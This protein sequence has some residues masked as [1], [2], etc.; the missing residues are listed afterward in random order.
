MVSQFYPWS[1]RKLWPAQSQ[2]PRKS[3]GWQQNSGLSWNTVAFH[4]FTFTCILQNL[5]SSQQLS[6]STS[7]E[8][9]KIIC[10]DFISY[11]S[12]LKTLLAEKN[13]Q[14]FMIAGFFMYTFLSSICNPFLPHFPKVILYRLPKNCPWQGLNICQ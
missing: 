2:I 10:A 12:N 8:N 14:C 6:N 3:Q 4:L 11:I 5:K 1:S 7:Q 9:K 13:I